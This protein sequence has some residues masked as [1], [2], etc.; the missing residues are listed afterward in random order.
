MYLDEYCYI[1]EIGLY[2]FVYL[3]SVFWFCFATF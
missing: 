2:L 1:S 3:Y